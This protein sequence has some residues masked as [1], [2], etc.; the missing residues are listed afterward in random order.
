MTAKQPSIVNSHTNSLITLANSKQK[1]LFRG[2]SAFD[3]FYIRLYLKKETNARK[4]T[5][6]G[7]AAYIKTFVISL[8]FLIPSAHIFPLTI[9]EKKN[10]TPKHTP[11]YNIS[12]LNSL[13]EERRRSRKLYRTDV[14]HIPI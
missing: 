12:L 9:D 14:A 5:N 8:L 6:S 4:A 11:Q 3:T 7:N 10:T 2:N 13:S 1:A